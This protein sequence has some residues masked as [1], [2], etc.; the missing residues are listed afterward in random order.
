MSYVK[1][2]QFWAALEKFTRSSLPSKLKSLLSVCG[3]DKHQSFMKI[4][5]RTFSDIREYLAENGKKGKVSPADKELI[6]DLVDLVNRNPEYFI[7]NYC[8]IGNHTYTRSIDHT[9]TE[10]IAY[11]GPGYASSQQPVH[12]G[13]SVYP[14][15]HTNCTC[16]KSCMPSLITY[17]FNYSYHCSVSKTYKN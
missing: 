2:D 5:R 16:Y 8:T 6:L 15:C 9:F 12:P 13:Q 10:S 17:N 3:Y 7:T 14:V 1:G 11:T 4:N